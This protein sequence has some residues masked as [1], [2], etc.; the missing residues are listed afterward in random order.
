VTADHL[1]AVLLGDAELEQDRLL[2]LLVFPYLYL[3]GP[4]DQRP[5]EELEQVLQPIP[6]AFSRFFTA[7][8]GWAPWPSQWRTRSSFS[9][10]VEGSVWA[11]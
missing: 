4:V 9:S 10:I 6:F 7:A 8:L 1:A 3:V 5:G 11:L 2:V